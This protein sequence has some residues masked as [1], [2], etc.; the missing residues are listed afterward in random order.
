M[1]DLNNWIG[2]TIQTLV[3]VGAIG[4]FVF[5]LQ[6]ALKLLIEQ[7]AQYSVRMLKVEAKI[8]QLSQVLIDLARQDARLN[9]QEARIQ[10]ISNRLHE[11]SK[12]G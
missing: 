6:L 11:Y 2:T 1:G 8:E 5:R 10:E 9:N 4:G 7:Q 12:R 3:L